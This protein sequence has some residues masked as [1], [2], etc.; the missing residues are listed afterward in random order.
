[1]SPA[2][3]ELLEAKGF[4]VAGNDFMD[5]NPRGYTYGDVFET[6]DGKRVVMQGSGGMGS[7]RVTAH[8]VGET[9][10]TEQWYAR[11][12]LKGVEQ[13]GSNRGYDR[14]LMNPPFSDRRDA[15]HVQHAYELLR[16]GGRLVALMGEG[17]FFGRDQKA[18]DFRAWLD[19]IG[20]TSEKL[21]EGTFT[22]PSLP[23]NTGVNAR[24]VVIDKPVGDLLEQASQIKFMRNSDKESAQYPRSP[25]QRDANWL[26]S[27]LANHFENDEW[28][29]AYEIPILPDD[30]GQEQ[31]AFARAFNKRIVPVVPTDPKFD[32]AE[33]FRIPRQPGVL[34]VKFPTRN[35][36]AVA[37]HE[38]YHDLAD[39]HS[40]LHSWFVKQAQPYIKNL[41][42]YQ[43][44]LNSLLL[45]GEA[46]YVAETAT[47]ELLADFTG[48]ALADPV[49]LK[50]LAEDNPGKFKELLTAVTQWLNKLV[51][52]LRGNRSEEFITDVKALRQHLAEVMKAYSDG[53]GPGPQGGI[54]FSRSGNFTDDIGLTYGMKEPRQGYGNLKETVTT[55]ADK[56][57]ASEALQG[58]LEA[59][60][61]LKRATLPQDRS[62]EAKEVSRLIIEGLGEKEMKSVRFRADLGKAVKQ[63]RENLTLAEKA[64]DL[65][66]KGLTVAADRLFV[67]KPKEDNYAFMQAMDTGD[68]AYFEAHPEMKK[69]A[70]IVGKMFSD[71]AAEVQ[72]L[73][74]GALEYV[75]ENYFPHIWNREPT[76]DAQRQIFSTLAKRPLEGKKSFSKQR[77]FD[78]FNAGIEAG[79]E[80][81][82][83]NPLDLVMLKMEEM[84]KYILAHQTL[85]AMEGSESVN[86]IPAGDKT[87]TGYTDINGRFGSVDR[88]GEKMRYVARDDVAQVI[89]NYLSPSLY[90][91]KYVGKPFSA[92]MKAANTL[93][94]FQLG[95]FSAFHAGFTSFE[96]VISHAALGLK[97]LS[98]GDFAGAAKYLKSAPMA[99]LNN[100]KMGDKIIQ[101]MMQHGTHPEM[102]QIIEGLQLAG[103][104]YQLDNR[105]RTDATKKMLES[106]SEGNK[107]TAG[108]HAIS[109]IVEQSA[110]PIMEW[111]VPRQKFGVFG[112][113]YSKW[114]HDNPNASH[115]AMR[116]SAQQ[117]WN[118]VDSRL[119]QVAYDRL[120][121]HNVTKNFAQMMIRAPGWTGGTILEVGGG[122]KDLAKYAADL[123]TG[124]ATQGLSDRAAYTLSM[125]LVTALSNAL[126]TAM[127]T[128]GSPD[129][130]KDLVAFRTGNLDNHGRAE[131]FMLPTY[132]KDVYSYSEHPFKTLSDKTHPLLSLGSNIATN[133]QFDGTEI[134]SQD[135][136][137]FVQ[138]GQVAGFSAGAFV[139]FWIKG[140]QKESQRG[141]EPI[142]MAMP[143]IG[144]MPAAS[145]FN[146]STAERMMSEFAAE[147]M[148]GTRTQAEAD[149]TR[150]RGQMYADIRK[151]DREAAMETFRQGR[152]DGILTNKDFAQVSK[153]GNQDPLVHSFSHLTYEQAQRVMGVAS[154]DEK[155]QL[156]PI[157]AHKRALAVKNG[158]NVGQ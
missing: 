37:G 88:D 101:E 64:R 91:N 79:Y 144:V 63:N 70:E 96:A 95:T 109:A 71:K 8:P 14:I 49:F 22:D 103:F 124:K 46:P 151:G 128:G 149:R 141:G 47:E 53:D 48:D 139:P 121:L 115:Q 67:G 36:I 66:E 98:T 10:R 4:Y 132:M 57:K 146:Q 89:N 155:A 154:D 119:G 131:R 106:W 11:E 92:Y 30:G 2:R 29:G 76:G 18:Q 129:D 122:I 82:S 150:L 62:A 28:R 31:K 56:L 34:Y 86:L 27:E 21:D 93:N 100:P 140:I 111:L 19:A 117:I 39:S 99:W 26:N 73:G 81:L 110:R 80:P 137:M 33:G 50:Q 138:L 148:P 15:Q 1:M 25:N 72:A 116:N 153:S 105:F 112:E 136:N 52:R 157:L 38:L 85:Q 143:L 118:R 107:A 23:V 135:E 90:H 55:A 152:A 84:D 130:W 58:V 156:G 102:A 147:R 45:P 145:N 51:A 7:G 59:I 35:F 126:L 77:V 94:Q 9:R 3:R 83:T 97:A 87:P 125:L 75:R 61:G 114:L 13:T 127:F 16:P 41:Q 24:M 74:T 6:P 108:F 142:S 40:Q 12:D 158:M 65:I 69:V 123:A 54:K 60:D 32:L 134:R 5:M 78:D 68:E 43:D 120:F 104:K 44:K 17:V 20:G 42:A 133:R 113:M